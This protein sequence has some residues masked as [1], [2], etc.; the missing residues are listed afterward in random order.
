MKDMFMITYDTID[1]DDV[2][3]DIGDIGSGRWW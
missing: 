2:D 1:V 3:D